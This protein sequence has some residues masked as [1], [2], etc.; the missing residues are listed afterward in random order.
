MARID[1]YIPHSYI[2][3]PTIIRIFFL[4][5]FSCILC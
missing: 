4:L 1:F 2:F 5:T 3:R